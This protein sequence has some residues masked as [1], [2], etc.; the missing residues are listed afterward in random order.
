MNKLKYQRL[1]FE[2]RKDT[3]SKVY[4]QAMMGE[5]YSTISKLSEVG[6]SYGSLCCCIMIDSIGL[7]SDLCTAICTLILFHKVLGIIID[8]ASFNAMKVQ[9]IFSSTTDTRNRL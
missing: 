7:C 5:T 4:V 8:G 9:D 1:I 2:N 3:F 6:R